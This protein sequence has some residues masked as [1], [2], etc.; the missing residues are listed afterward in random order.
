M[1]YKR[2]IGIAGA[3]LVCVLTLYSG[4]SLSGVACSQHDMR[5]SPTR[6]GV[7]GCTL[8][9]S[10]SQF[11][12][13][14]VQVCVFCHTPHSANKDVWQGGIFNQPG[15]GQQSYYPSGAY[16]N[17][18]SQAA[19]STPLLL[20]NRALSSQTA[21]SVY[22]SSTMNA[23]TG[24]LR[25]YSLLCLSCHDGVTALNVV[26]NGPESTGTTIPPYFGSSTWIGDIYNAG[27]LS[28]WGVNIGERVNVTNELKLANDHPISFDYTSGLVAN[29][30]A[31][32]GPGLRQP[33][34]GG[35]VN[36]T[37]VKLFYSY[38][39]G[40]RTSME[41]STCHDVHNKYNEGDHPYDPSDPNYDINDPDD[42]LYPLLTMTLRNS[43]LCLNCHLK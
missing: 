14:T 24:T 39:T 29:D 22:T 6:E 9:P 2:L 23:Y 34:V 37:D 19:S 17:D 5:D 8:A 16:S 30:A 12:F 42:Y 10:G 4:I 28:G 15:A 36:H 25:I 21:Y 13:E 7:G 18:V 27:T 3:A 31:P 40:Q 38:S 20:W 35:F 11:Q 32:T 26:K 33:D 43:A 41:C 1:S